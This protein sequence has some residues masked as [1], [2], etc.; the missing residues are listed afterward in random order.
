MNYSVFTSGA[1]TGLFI[2]MTPE[3]SIMDICENRP[4]LPTNAHILKDSKWGVFY[5]T[6]PD[7]NSM[8]TQEEFDEYTFNNYLNNNKC[9]NGYVYYI[10]NGGKSDYAMHF[11]NDMI[12]SMLDQKNDCKHAFRKKETNKH[13]TSVVTNRIKTKRK[14]PSLDNDISKRAKKLSF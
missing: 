4:Y 2:Q 13:T 9:C 6:I 3:A 7:E 1:D 14:A 12:I 5:S 8:A 10:A 11:T